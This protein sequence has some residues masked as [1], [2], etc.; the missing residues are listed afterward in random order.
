MKTQEL[1]DRWIAVAKHHQQADMF[2]QGSWLQSEKVGN[3][4]KGCMFGCFTQSKENTLEKAAEE[5]QLPLWIV[6]VAERIFEGLKKEKAVLFPLKFIE[7]IKINQDWDKVYKQFHHQN[8]MNQ[9]QYCG[10]NQQC[11]GAVKQCADLFLMDEI[12][13]EAAESAARSAESAAW[14]A[15]RSAAG[16]ARSAAGSARSAW[17]AAGSAESAAWSAGSA[18]WSAESAGSARS[19]AYYEWMDNLLLT[20]MATDFVA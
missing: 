8:L 20:L 19:A 14:S 12:T 16:S 18:A 9:I 3:E 4:Y 2:I 5:M 15:A 10:D 7:A 11:I 17:S 13:E 1:K 6:A